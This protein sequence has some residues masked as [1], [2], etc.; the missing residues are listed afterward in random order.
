[1]HEMSHSCG[2]WGGRIQ[3]FLLFGLAVVPWDAGAHARVSSSRCTSSLEAASDLR[4]CSSR[5]ARS[6]PV[7]VTATT[8]SYAPVVRAWSERVRSFGLGQQ[9]VI[10]IDAMD[11][12]DWS[13]SACAVRYTD[14]DRRWRRHA[15]SFLQRR[16]FQ[17][18]GR[19]AIDRLNASNF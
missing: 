15:G 10:A 18:G 7:V 17:Q 11:R 1:M 19:R 16:F 2:I 6:E 14:E 4:R 5:F 3:E 13:D 9:V 8:E 12:S